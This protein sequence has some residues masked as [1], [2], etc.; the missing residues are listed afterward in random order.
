VWRVGVD[1]LL[2][3]LEGQ[4]ASHSTSGH[5][6]RFDGFL[7]RRRIGIDGENGRW[8]GPGHRAAQA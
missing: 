3:N 7:K 8:D 5:S 2:G 4:R 6:Q 1:A